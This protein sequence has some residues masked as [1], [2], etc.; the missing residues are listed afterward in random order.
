[1]TVTNKNTPV[2]VTCRD[3]IPAVEELAQNG[4]KF[5][6]MEHLFLI[7]TEEA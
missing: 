3:V 2:F 4:L 7:S 1:M 6:L 5:I